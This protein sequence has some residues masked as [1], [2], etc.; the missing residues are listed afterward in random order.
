[1]FGLPVPK[2]IDGRVLTEIFKKE[3]GPGQREVAYQDVYY[4][5]ERIRLKAKKLKRLKKL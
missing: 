3:N 4:E 2:D 5:L 1:M